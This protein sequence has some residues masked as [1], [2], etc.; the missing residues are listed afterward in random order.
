[1]AL[2]ASFATVGDLSDYS[3]YGTRIMGSD[4]CISC[5]LIGDLPM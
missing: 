3:H 5:G 4:L 1:M 2:G